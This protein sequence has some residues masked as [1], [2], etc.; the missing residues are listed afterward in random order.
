M[1]SKKF[2]TSRLTDF[3]KKLDFI[4]WVAIS[5]K[6]SPAIIPHMIRYTVT[7]LWSKIGDT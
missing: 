3:A 1:E 2:S 4:N 7:R 6:T 5:S